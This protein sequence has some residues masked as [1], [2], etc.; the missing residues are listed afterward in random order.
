MSGPSSPGEA[1]ASVEPSPRPSPAPAHTSRS[2]P[3][4][5]DELAESVTLI[6]AAGGSAASAVA[7][8]RDRARPRRSG[9]T[10]FRNRLGPFDVLV[11]GA[12]IVG[13]IGPLWEVDAR[14]VVGD[15]GGQR[16]AA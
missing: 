8:V 15:H 9:G 10:A 12:G 7:D 1:G 14:R 11:N 13:P 3:A 16:G 5:A 6:E 4:R 2:W